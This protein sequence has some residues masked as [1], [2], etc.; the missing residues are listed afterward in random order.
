[1][2]SL[3]VEIVVKLIIGA[4]GGGRGQKLSH[5][6]LVKADV[7]LIATGF[8]VVVKVYAGFA[9]GF[10]IFLYK[11]HNQKPPLKI[12]PPIPRFYSNIKDL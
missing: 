7:A 4:V 9:V 8:V 3:Q 12:I 5:F 2:F 11:F 10:G 6:V 1:M